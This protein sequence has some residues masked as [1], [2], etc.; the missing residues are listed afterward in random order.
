MWNGT[1][2]SYA[3]CENADKNRLKTLDTRETKC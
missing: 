2:K 3:Y 1:K